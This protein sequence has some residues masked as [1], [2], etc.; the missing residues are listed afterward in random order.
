MP[1]KKAAAERASTDAVSAYTHTAKRKNIPPAGLESEGRLE[2]APKLRFDYNPHLPPALRS[3]PSLVVPPSG[4]S[5]P[6]KAGTTNPTF[7]AATTDLLPELLQLARQRPLTEPEARL[8]AD[9]LRRHE[10][11][12]EWS[13]KRE[14]PWF[15]VEPVA[16]HLHERVSTQAILRVLAREDVQRDLFADPQQDYAKAVQF[17]QHDV[18]WANRMILGDSLAVMASLAR[19]EDLAGKVQMIYFDPPYGIK[20]ASNFQPSLGQRDVKDKPQDLTR[21]PEMVRAYRDTWTLGI[22]SYLAYLR[23][24]LTMAKE[25]LADTGSIFVQI[26]D[27]NLHRVRLLFDEVF[28]PANF[29]ALI[30]FAKTSSATVNFLPQTCDYLIWY[31]KDAV[32]AK[33]RPLF[34]E[35]PIAVE[36]SAY[37]SIEMRSGEHRRLS[38]AEKGEARD[39][40]SDGKIYRIDNLQSQSVGRQKGEGAACWF[41]VAFAGQHW[42]PSIQGRWKTNEEGMKRIHNSERLEATTG[43]LYYVRFA[44]DFSVQ[45]INNNWDDTGIAGF[46][47]D[48]IYVVQTSGKVIERCLLM[49]SD[50][51]DLVLD[52][53]C[54]SGT[55]A[56]VAEQW[57]RRWIT[58]DTSRVA[59]ALARQR[60]MTARFTSYRLRP[61]NAEDVARNPRGHWLKPV[62]GAPPSGTGAGDKFTFACKTVPHITLKSIA[63][64]TSLDPIFAQHEPI[65]AEKLVALNKALAKHATADLCERLADKLRRKEREEGKK[66]VT[67]ADRRRWILPKVNHGGTEATEKT[68][69]P[70]SGSASSASSAFQSG[71]REWE[72]PFD[73]DPDWPKPLS[74]ALTA[75]RAAWRAKMDEVNAAIQANAEQEELVDKPEPVSGV[76]RVAGPFTMEG[77]I[78]VE[79]SVD[80]PI[81]GAPDGA[82]EFF[83]DAAP[84]PRSDDA[85]GASHPHNDPQNA[86]A[87][88]DKVLRLLKAAGVDFAGGKRMTFSQLAP[89]T[90]ASLVHAEGEWLNGDK[91]ERRV[92]V[93]IGPEVGSLSNYQVEEVLHAASRRG[94]DDVVFA[95]F[96]FDAAAQATI[97]ADPNP[98]VRLHM[99]LIRP[100]VAMGDLL[101]TQPGSQIFTVFTAPRVAKPEKSKDGQWTV[102][103]EGMD[104]YDPVSG[105]L[106]ACNRDRIASWFLDTNYDGRTFCICQAFFPDKT[107]WAKLAKALGDIGAVEEERFEALSGLTSLAFPRP[108]REFRQ[109]EPWRI[110]IKVIDPR[111]QEGL[112]VVEMPAP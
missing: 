41:P 58:C 1:R 102:T 87:H 75:Y 74:D 106:D 17:Y 91:R 79:D 98:R 49:T 105:T 63:R 109:G 44:E 112:R 16:L 100:D 24:R 42:R 14:K 4:G 88:L 18:D 96:A 68:K 82:L 36:G 38:S 37:G 25:L 12:L 73:T 62:D 9:A 39:W 34:I 65:L 107:K 7:D 47:S 11:W 27:E 31:A 59:L 57:G 85:T 21:E 3:A 64:N 67:E 60:L 80:T 43:G 13:G 99:A 22:H 86:E 70:G 77:V 101:K 46:A 71:W 40:V 76:V 2:E 84:S 61:V 55:T 103:V 78:A 50:P 45:P 29:V 108:T 6:S 33:F 90:G 72:V 89:V 28:G 5:V 54:G 93:S 26:S 15:E 92:A 66:S 52:P 48:K 32:K 83:G 19:R 51:G 30:A 94:Y 35:K 10:P 53:T 104:I 111:G 56:F 97:A 81:G 20:F 95:A 69:S 8:L 23:D 110:A